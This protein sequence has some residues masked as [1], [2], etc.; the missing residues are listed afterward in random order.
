MDQQIE[1]KGDGIKVTTIDPKV[2]HVETE[3][4]KAYLHELRSINSKLFWFVLLSVLSIIGQ[5]LNWMF[6][7]MLMQ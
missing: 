2:P 5:L 1:D 4:R 6:G 7:Q 3:W